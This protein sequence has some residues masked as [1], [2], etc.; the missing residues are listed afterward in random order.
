MNDKILSR[1]QYEAIHEFTAF[2]KQSEK[3]FDPEPRTV[4]TGVVI[5]ADPEHW[6]NN[7]WEA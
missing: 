3:G 2:R 4:K 5:W 6:K 1:S 7:P